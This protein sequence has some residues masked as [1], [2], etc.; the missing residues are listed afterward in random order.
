MRDNTNSTPRKLFYK[1]TSFS[2]MKCEE[3][4]KNQQ[5]QIATPRIVC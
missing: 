3:G 1:V 5:M 2:F 4:E